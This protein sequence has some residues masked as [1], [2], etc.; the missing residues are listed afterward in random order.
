MID[1]HMHSEQKIP[2]EKIKSV[3]MENRS[4]GAEGLK[5]IQIVEQPEKF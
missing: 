3:K 4:K 2:E 1:R 5:I